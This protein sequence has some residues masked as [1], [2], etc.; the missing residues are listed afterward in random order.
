MVIS[1]FKSD[2][3]VNLVEKTI[4]KKIYV[5]VLACVSCCTNLL[6]KPATPCNP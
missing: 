3:K 1:L 6:C 5:N 2:C 4:M